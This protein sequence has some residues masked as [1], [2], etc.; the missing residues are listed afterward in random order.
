MLILLFVC[1]LLLFNL[2]FVLIFSKF[3]GLVYYDCYTGI[4]CLSREILFTSVICYSVLFK[5]LMEPQNIANI[6]DR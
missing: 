4:L 6:K 1:Y 3:T 2:I 5:S